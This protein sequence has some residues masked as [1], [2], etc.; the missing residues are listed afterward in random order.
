MRM[1]MKTKLIH[2]KLYQELQP[3]LNAY[4]RPFFQKSEILSIRA[5]LRGSKKLNV[6]LWENRVSMLK[7]FD[8]YLSEEKK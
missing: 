2:S 8:S 1:A 6:F 4:I 5:Q 3:F 7:I